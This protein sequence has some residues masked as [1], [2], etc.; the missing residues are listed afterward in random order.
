MRQALDP[1]GVILIE[2]ATVFRLLDEIEARGA[3]R[4]GDAWLHR[5]PGPGGA[6]VVGAGLG[7]M[8]QHPP[9]DARAG[10]QYHHIGATPRV[11]GR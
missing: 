10:F 3:H 4:R 2:E 7:A 6:E 9:A 11:L 8:A 5:R 1:P